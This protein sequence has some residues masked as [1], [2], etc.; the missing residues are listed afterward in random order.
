MA[1]AANDKQKIRE[2]TCFVPQQI[3]IQMMDNL[4][5]KQRENEKITSNQQ[6]H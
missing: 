4:K 3:Q 1:Q 5:R 6:S 2:N